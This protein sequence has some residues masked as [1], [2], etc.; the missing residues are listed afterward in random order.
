MMPDLPK[1]EIAVIEMTNAFRK[2]HTL[3]P[4]KTDA[5]LA[6]AARAYARHLASTGRFTHEADGKK[7][8]QRAEAQGYR[9]CFVAE[10]LAVDSNRAGFTERGLA[11]EFMAGWKKSDVHRANLLMRGATDI[12]I[13]VAKVPDHPGRYVSVQMLARPESGRIAFT[14]ENKAGFPVEYRI[15]GKGRTLAD[16]KAITFKGCNPVALTFPAGARVEYEPGNG[17]TFT[18]RAA[19]SDRVIVERK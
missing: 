9:F 18:V 5:R 4:V 17:E 12:G 7:P 13:G 1:T 10:N 19:G 3:G 11:Q 8:H 14:I 6:A 15:S 16:S 2:E